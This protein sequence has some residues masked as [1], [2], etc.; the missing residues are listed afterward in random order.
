RKI[1]ELYYTIRL[2]MFYSKEQLLT[3]YLNTIYF[4]HGAYGISEASQFYFGKQVDDL[5]LAEATMLIGIPKGP[6]YYSPYNNIENATERQH[7]I[8]KKLLHRELITEA[9]FYQAKGENLV[10]KEKTEARASSVDY[11]IDYV[12]AE[13]LEQLSL[14]KESLLAKNAKIHTTL[15]YILQEA[16]EVKLETKA[17][18]KSDLEVGII[19]LD[20]ASGA[21]RQ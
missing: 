1:K 4:G 13:A 16:S 7:F 18:D 12:F 10:F 9:N 17:L 3:S 2:E 21:I 11:F 15:D 19:S 8:L 6:T 5:S 14:T 20:Q